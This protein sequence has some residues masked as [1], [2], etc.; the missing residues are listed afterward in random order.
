MPDMKSLR[1]FTLATRHGHMVRFVA[2]T[3][4]FVPDA[5][6]HD[7]MAA[8]CVPVND[9]DAARIDDNQAIKVEFQ[10][11]L[12]RAVLLLVSRALANENDTKHFSGGIPTKK[13]V[14]ER[15]GFDAGAAEIR[16]AWRAYLHMKKSGEPIDTHPEAMNVLRVVEASTLDELAKLAEEFDVA[17]DR[18]KGLSARELRRLLLAKFSG[19]S[20]Q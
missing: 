6:V 16:D 4:T 15:A 9:E 14:A 13:A 19:I 3:T 10:G 8:G 18:R 2:N 20:A 12:R 7:A 11:D 17:E 5:A 1:T